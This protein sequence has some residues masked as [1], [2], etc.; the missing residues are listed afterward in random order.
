M[1]KIMNKLFV[2]LFALM[3][4]S[5]LLLSC[6][7]SAE[8]TDSTNDSSTTDS[9][10]T[11]SS[12]TNSSTTDSSTTDSG[13]ADDKS[14]VVIDKIIYTLSGEEYHV[15]GV[16][17]G[18]G[19]NLVILEECEGLPVTKILYKAFYQLENLKS[20]TI[21]KTIVE[22]EEY[23]GISSCTNL[24]RLTVA[25][26]NASYKSID[27]NLYTED[28]K[29]LLLYAA[30][31]ADESFAVSESVDTIYSYAFKDA[32]NLKNVDF[33]NVKNIGGNAFE[34]CVN[35]EAVDFSNVK[36]IDGLAFLNCDSLETVT[37]SSSVCEIGNGAF[38][39]C[40]SLKE[41]LVDERNVFYK[42]VD[43]ILF[44]KI[45]GYIL[46][47]YPAGK[48]DTEIIFDGFEGTEIAPDSFRGAN[49]IVSIV[50]DE[51]STM[52][53]IGARA[54]MGCRGLKSFFISED[55]M[56]SDINVA[57]FLDCESLETVVIN[58]AVSRM[59]YN[60][61]MGCDKLTIFLQLSESQI[62]YYVK[63]NNWAANWNVDG[64][65]VQYDY[66]YEN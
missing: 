63:F 28:G 40:S 15:A 25:E 21:P 19:E 35:L 51:M 47:Q 65:P 13:E 49:N 52:R 16:E 29:T 31:K 3:L 44:S 24:S 12:T 60:V 55:A 17:E 59:G 61:F 11:D 62:E 1:R 32:V 18:Y 57:S 54:F 45:E 37:I 46:Y 9:S 26:E 14:T 33:T 53:T 64:C 2:L 7:N 48:E 8:T 22:I 42:S 20:L 38:A 39:D 56:I 5:A 58:E 10:T 36:I 23:L 4:V 50:V 30:G 41:I 43:G 27:G 6:D 34:G 66:V